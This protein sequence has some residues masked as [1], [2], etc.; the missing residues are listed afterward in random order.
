MVV[1]DSLFL[2]HSDNALRGA[3]AAVAAL[4]VTITWCTIKIL[5]SKPLA[6]LYGRRALVGHNVG[7]DDESQAGALLSVVR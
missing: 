4:F 1:Q 6:E 2:Q 7:D 3:S 5:W